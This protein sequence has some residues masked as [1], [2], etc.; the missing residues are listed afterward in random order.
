MWMTE[1]CTMILNSTQLAEFETTR[2]L[3][4]CLVNECLVDA[5]VVHGTSFGVSTWLELRSLKDN[6]GASAATTTTIRAATS[7]DSRLTWTGHPLKTLLQPNDLAPPVVVSHGNDDT[8]PA[9][10]REIVE[11]NPAILF[12]TAGHWFLDNGLKSEV[13]E[14]MANELRNSAQNQGPSPP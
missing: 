5:S 4:S 8:D 7:P 2:R 13:R 14:Q 3:L 12:E 9:A 10:R 1:C 6:T 11:L